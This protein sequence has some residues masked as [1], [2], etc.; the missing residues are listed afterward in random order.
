MLVKLRPKRG[1]SQKRS[2]ALF[3]AWQP[4]R[5]TRM[6]TTCWLRQATSRFRI[7]R[8]AIHRRSPFY[9]PFTDSRL[10]SVA[11][12]IQ[13]SRSSYALLLVLDDN[14]ISP[15]VANPPTGQQPWRLGSKRSSSC[16]LYVDTVTSLQIFKCFPSSSSPKLL[17]GLYRHAS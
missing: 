13:L 12:E 7:T 1:A 15:V 5:S 6:S 9:P 4:W 10:L 17:L 16:L 11:Q 14:H 8:P 2:S 3:V